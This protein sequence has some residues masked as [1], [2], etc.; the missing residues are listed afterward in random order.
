MALKA[1]FGGLKED[2]LYKIYDEEANSESWK[3]NSDTYLQ[4]RQDIEDSIKKYLASAKEGFKK[5]SNKNPVLWQTKLQEKLVEYHTRESST[6]RSDMKIE[7][8]IV[9]VSFKG[10]IYL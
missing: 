8:Q 2:D 9:L 10:R 1:K 5:E 3:S 7:D 6:W 4:N